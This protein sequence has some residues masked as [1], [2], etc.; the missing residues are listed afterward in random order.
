M[1]T[2]T[3]SGKPKFEKTPPIRMTRSAYQPWMLNKYGMMQRPWELTLTFKTDTVTL[4]FEIFY[5]Y[6]KK[7]ND[8]NSE[9]REREPNRSL[10]LMPP[11]TYDGRLAYRGSS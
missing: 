7:K 5:F 1:Q 2:E 6:S 11:D 3:A 9:V 4:P 10:I 8:G